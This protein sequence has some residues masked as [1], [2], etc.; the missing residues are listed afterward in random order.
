MR[1]AVS[2]S[3]MRTP[4]LHTAVLANDLRL[5]KTMIRRDRVEVDKRDC[6]GATPLM[7]AALMG[8][9]AIVAYLPEKGAAWDMRDDWGVT[10]IQYAQGSF[11]E[12]LGTRYR[13]PTNRRPSTSAAQRAHIA[14]HLLSTDAL[15]TQYRTKRSG[16]VFFHRAGSFLRVSKLITTVRLGRRITRDSTAGY[17]ACGNSLKPVMCAVSGW[18]PDRAAGLLDGNSYTA[19]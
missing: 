13:R 7:L 8:N 10:V 17:I 12:T 14:R 2:F 3:T 19:I 5:T 18:T 16:T 6:Y 15:R 11:A 9:P 1:S 4:P